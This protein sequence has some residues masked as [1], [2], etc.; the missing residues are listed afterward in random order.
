MAQDQWGG[1]LRHP[2]LD[3]VWR[4]AYA[5]GTGGGFL[6]TIHYTNADIRY[7]RSKDGK[8]LYAIVLGW[9]LGE[10][11]LHLPE[12]SSAEKNAMIT[13]LGHGPVSY[14]V[15]ED[16][17]LTLSLPN[18]SAKNRPCEHAYVFKLNGFDI[19]P[20]QD[21]AFDMPGAMTLSAAHAVFNGAQINLRNHHGHLNID[22]WHDAAESVHWLTYVEKPGVY[23]VRG[24]VSANQPCQLTLVGGKEDLVLEIP[25]TGNWYVNKVINFGTIELDKV[26]INHLTLKATNTK[27]HK[28]VGIWK[29]QLVSANTKVE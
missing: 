21:M 25:K 4:G 28:P 19:Q 8:T 3:L 11:T 23:R 14:K 5:Y 18:L 13:L 7:T 26:G 22:N 10:L 2:S 24:E 17:R 27:K 1:D 9:P 29:L 12:I 16:K 15:G 20:S 6:D